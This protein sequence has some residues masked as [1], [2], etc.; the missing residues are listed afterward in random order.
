MF[1]AVS[2]QPIKE[3]ARVSS[4]ASPCGICG[5]QSGTRTDS[6]PSTGVLYYH[7]AINAPFSSFIRLLLTLY[8]LS[9]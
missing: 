5:A 9:N 6:S 4:Q 8:S 7:H 2:Q 1:Q 3:V